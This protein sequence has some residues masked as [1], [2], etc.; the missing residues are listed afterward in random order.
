MPA[1]W[2]C[3]RFISILTGRRP[4]DDSI[5]IARLLHEFD[6]SE[7]AM[8]FRLVNLTLIDPA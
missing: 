8:R 6:V 4:V 1:D 5:A 7:E 3:D 2:V